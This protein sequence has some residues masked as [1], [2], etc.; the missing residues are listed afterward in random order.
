MVKIPRIHSTLQGFRILIFFFIIT[1]IVY[2]FMGIRFDI[3]PLYWFFQFIDPLLLKTELLKS[4]LYLH[5][6]PPCFNLFLGLIIKLANNS[7]VLIFT[8][9]YQMIGLI[10]VL[11][12]YTILRKLAVPLRITLPLTMFFAISPPVIFLEN[13][14]FYTYPATCL[15]ALSLIFLNNYFD[16]RAYTHLFLFFSTIALIVLTRSLFHPIWFIITLVGIVACDRHNAKRI[17]LCALFPLLIIGAVHVKNYVLFKQVGLSSWFGMNLAKMTLTVPLEKIE[18]LVEKGELSSIATIMP[19]QTP[20]TYREYANFDTLTCKRVLDQKYKSTGSPNLNHIGYMHVSQQ[21]LVAAKYLIRKYPHYYGLSVCKAFYA[22]L[23]PCSDSMIIRNNNRRVIGPWVNIYE[24]YL[25]GDILSRVWNTHY[26]N[27]YGQKR[28][29]HLN[30]LYFLLPVLF[31]WG[32]ITIAK[33][34]TLF[35]YGRAEL[36]TITYTIFNIIYITIAGNLLEVSENMR[37][38][39]LILPFL[40]IFSGLLLKYLLDRTKR[41]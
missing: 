19:F 35:N 7:E 33:G 23:R 1:R 13:W 2:Y 8:L 38:R 34:K 9:A 11:S 6:Q 40:Y 4:I 20:E 18:P 31:I 14:L 21:Y 41:T 5:T 26:T 17:I 24:N 12:L 37:F 16:K 10:M 22:F 15:L 27:R 3:T 32:L 30:F 25:V 29:I 28:K 39:F 36:I